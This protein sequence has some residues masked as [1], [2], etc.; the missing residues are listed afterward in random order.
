MRIFFAIGYWTGRVLIWL[1]VS[2]IY[3]AI[4]I[5][6]LPKKVHD[7]IK[8][9]IRPLWTAYVGAG[10][11]LFGL[12][13]GIDTFI[14]LGATADYIFKACTTF[15]YPAG[16]GRFIIE[17]SAFLPRWLSWRPFEKKAAQ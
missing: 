12:W 7:I 15:A 17:A 4:F 8:W 10:L 2:F 13:W 1:L 9:N 6:V 16:V 5:L 14:R 11:I 3:G